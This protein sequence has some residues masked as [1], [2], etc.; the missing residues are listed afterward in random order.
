[1]GSRGN[2]VVVSTSFTI[3]SGRSFVADIAGRL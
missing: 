1:M 2:I 3:I